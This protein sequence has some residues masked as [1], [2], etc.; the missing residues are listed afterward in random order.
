MH[1]AILIF[2]F[3]LPNLL[4]A[5]TS[6]ASEWPGL[7]WLDAKQVLTILKQQPGL[8]RVLPDQSK[9]SIWARK[10]SIQR[11]TIAGQDFPGADGP[12]Y[13]AYGPFDPSRWDILINGVIVDPREFLILYDGSL[14]NLGMLFT[15]RE[16]LYDQGSIRPPW[17]ADD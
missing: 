17:W 1:V 12:W 3:T 6:A 14:I 9:V 4:A 10:V 16:E 11:R 5:Q 7:R 2:V 8:L 13:L 15:F